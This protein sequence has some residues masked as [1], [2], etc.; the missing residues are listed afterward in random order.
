M[1]CDPATFAYHIGTGPW[2]RGYAVYYGVSF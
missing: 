1:G 2:S